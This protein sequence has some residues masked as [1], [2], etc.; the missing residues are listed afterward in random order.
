MDQWNENEDFKILKDFCKSL[1]VTIDHA[2]RSVALVQN[3][4]GRL[5]KE[6][7]QLTAVSFASRV[8]APQ[9][10]FQTTEECTT[11]TVTEKQ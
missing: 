4:S 8:S 6:E 5:T 11:V 10:I 9:K 1:A 2:E 7:K 3:F